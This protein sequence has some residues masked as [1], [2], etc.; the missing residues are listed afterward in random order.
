MSARLLVAAAF[1]GVM[2][3]VA[4]AQT[5][6]GPQTLA[7]LAQAIA[8][9]IR[10]TTRTPPGAPISL[11]SATSHDNVVEI[12]YAVA[13]AAEFARLKAD[14]E[15]ARSSLVSFYCRE[16]RRAFFEQGG[17]VH[18]VYALS[19][20]SDQV[21]FTVDKSSCERL[22]KVEPADAKTLA[23]LALAAAKAENETVSSKSQAEFRLIEATAHQGVVDLRFV[24]RD[25]ATAAAAQAEE[26]TLAGY[27]SGYLCRKYLDSIHR[28]LVFHAVFAV[29]GNPPAIELTIDHSKC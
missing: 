17:V 7:E 28:G 25:A 23:E 15:K 10:A 6:Q 12:R 27:V 14:A 11:A 9:T 13:D 5:G 16:Q 8:N 18:Q 4:G 3:G 21:E 2:L 20:G 1:V 24:I 29:Q 22:P 19:G 26:W